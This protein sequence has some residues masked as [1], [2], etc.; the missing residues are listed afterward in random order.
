MN[1]NIIEGAWRQFKG[2]AVGSWAKL[3]GDDQ[4]R[5][6]AQQ[7]RLVGRLQRRYGVL[8]AE[9][10]RRVDHWLARL[11]DGRPRTLRD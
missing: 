1:R 7:D 3:T 11:D 4:L 5:I 10:E 6:R 8:K 2:A 9:A